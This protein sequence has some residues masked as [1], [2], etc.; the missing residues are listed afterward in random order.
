M[1]DLIGLRCFVYRTK[2]KT[3]IH[4]Q[5]GIN[6]VI[7]SSVLDFSETL[8]T[9]LY[10]LLTLFNVIWGWECKWSLLF[11]ATAGTWRKSWW[12]NRQEADQRMSLSSSVGSKA[13][14]SI[15]SK[16]KEKSPLS[17]HSNIYCYNIEVQNFMRLYLTIL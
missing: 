15:Q 3:N 13:T 7:C 16:L 6:E 1:F 2:K 17:N 4:N 11:Q 10:G 14:V 5:Y 12:R 9:C 8:N